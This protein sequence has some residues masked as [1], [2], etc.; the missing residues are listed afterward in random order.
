MN[1]KLGKYTA[2]ENGYLG[3]KYS[4]YDE[5][6]DLFCNIS[7]HVVENPKFGWERVEEA[8]KSTDTDWRKKE[9]FSFED[10][11]KF[12]VGLPTYKVYEFVIIETGVLEKEAKKRTKK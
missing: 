7:E 4:V 12:K 8:E 5:K 2:K 1:Y 11:L 3:Q 10:L 6:G 9:V